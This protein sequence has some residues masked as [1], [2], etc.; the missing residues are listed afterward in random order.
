MDTTLF[1]TSGQW[2]SGGIRIGVAK[3]DPQAWMGAVTYARRG[4]LCAVLGIVAD[5]DDDGNEASKNSRVD[6]HGNMTARPMAQSVARVMPKA[7]T[8]DNVGFPRSC[9]QCGSAVRDNRP[10]IASGKYKPK[11][12]HWSCTSSTC[13]GPGGKYRTSG[14]IVKGGGADGGPE[15]HGEP[16]LDEGMAY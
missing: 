5:D 3:G 12:P 14:W 10:D 16:P 15:M 7:A 1:H 9:P 2:V 8:T 13:K 6:G 4:S 11:Y